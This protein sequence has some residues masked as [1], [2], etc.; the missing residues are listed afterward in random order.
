[1]QELK[2]HG[3]FEPQGPVIVVVLD[4][5]GIGRK[6]E[7]DAVHLARTPTMDWLDA[8]SFKTTLLAHG[9]HVGMP[10]DDDMG[11]SEVGHNALGAGRIYDQGAKR[12]DIAIRSGVLFDRTHKD[13]EG[14]FAMVDHVLAHQSTL[15]LIG[16]LSD[17]NVHSHIDHVIALVKNAAAQGIKKLRLHAM[18]DGRD[19]SGQS[20]HLYV[21]QIEDL[22]AEFN[23][24]G[25]DF[26][27]ASGGGRMLV[28]MDRYEAEWDMVERGWHAHVL[29]H[30]P[31]TRSAL[32]TIFAARKASPDLNDQY[33]P[34]FVVVDDAGNPVGPILDHDAVLL[35]NFRG[36]RA[37][38][39]SRAFEED[40]FEKF[41]RKRRPD[42]FLRA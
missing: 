5:V 29:G 23:N 31:K 13:S 20:A 16:L 36:D 22:F 27:I 26:Q 40:H 42:V 10:S 24:D 8:H 21:Q 37:I 15:H 11:N 30:G 19:V 3:K 4:G 6:D 41:D 38:E 28:T 39:L 2:R 33:I 7:G 35:F 1:M 32:E 17:G 14:W 12:V 9:T 25:F 18:T 34:P